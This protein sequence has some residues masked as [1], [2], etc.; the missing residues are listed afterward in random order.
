MGFARGDD[1]SAADTERRCGEAGLVALDAARGVPAALSSPRDGR[2]RLPNLTVAAPS[3]RST[4]WV[5][6]DGAC[7]I[8]RFAVFLGL[9][10]VLTGVIFRPTNGSMSKTGTGDR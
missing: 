2:T 5:V 10:G 6:T 1:V 4:C 9:A 8:T 7:D 3:R